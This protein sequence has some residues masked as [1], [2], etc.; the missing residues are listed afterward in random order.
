VIAMM[1]R[2][3]VYADPV[4]IT[5]AFI[6]RKSQIAHAHNA[7]FASAAFVTGGLDPVLS[8]NDFIALFDPLPAPLLVVYGVDTPPKSKAEIEALLELDAIE[9]R[10]LPGSLGLH[11]EHPKATREAV[12]P[13]LLKENTKA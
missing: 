4:K 3:H 13:F 12:E 5:P 9:R 1:Y 7:R 2:D 8:R 6:H 11:E 10:L